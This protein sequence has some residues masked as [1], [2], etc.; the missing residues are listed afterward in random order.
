M[1]A[2]LKVRSKPGGKFNEA[3]VPPKPANDNRRGALVKHSEAAKKLAGY[4]KVALEAHVPEGEDIPDDLTVDMAIVERIV[5]GTFW[6]ARNSKLYM[7]NPEDQ[8]LVLCS[9]ADAKTFIK[10]SHGYPVDVEA[11]GRALARWLPIDDKTPPVEAGI[12]LVSSVVHKQILD[13]LKYHNQRSSIEYRVDMFA[14]TARVELLENRARVVLTHKSLSVSN[15]NDDDVVADY[16]DHFPELNDVLE[17][18]VAARFAGDRKKAYLWLLAD[19]DWGKGFFLGVLRELGISVEMSVREVEALFEGKPVGRSPTDFVRAFVLVIDEFKSVK[20]E[21]K[22]LQSIIPLAPKFQMVSDVEVFAK[23]FTS[24]EQVRSLVGEHGVENQFANRFSLIEK[25]G[26][27]EERN[28]FA[29][30]KDHYHRVVTSYVGR[31]LNRMIGAFI[32]M[33]PGAAAKRGRDV[34]ESFIAEHGIARCYGRLSDAISDLAAEFVHWIVEQDQERERFNREARLIRYGGET[35]LLTPGNVFAEFVNT[36][37]DPSERA[38]IGRKVSGVL[39]EL[40]RDGK[41]SCSYRI[42][43]QKP[44]RAV[45]IKADYL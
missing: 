18:I 10:R 20:S 25:S 40:C 9:I 19:S 7:V 13:H 24:A 34:L 35:Y 27:I 23:L 22:Q 42:P 15:V 21:I 30:D 1:M 14:D 3:P 39:K 26:S 32:K 6:D 2:P 37:I 12:K 43:R 33:G 29:R 16:L 38:T 44:F 4:I 5:G 31:E 8:S 11:A 45:R 36:R 41:G 28:V 17:L